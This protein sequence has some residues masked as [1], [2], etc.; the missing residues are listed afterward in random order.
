MSLFCALFVL[1]CSGSKKA[2][3]PVE[4]WKAEV[5]G[6]PGSAK[7][8]LDAGITSVPLEPDGLP[9]SSCLVYADGIVDGSPEEKIK[10]LMISL[11]PEIQFNGMGWDLTRAQNYSQRLDYRTSTITTSWVDPMLG[12]FKIVAHPDA[13]NVLARFEI[14]FKSSSNGEL[15]ISKQTAKPLPP[16]FIPRGRLID[17]RAD[18]T[19]N[20]Q[21]DQYSAA[22]L[23][24]ETKTF[25]ITFRTHKLAPIV[26]RETP[27]IE[28]DGPEEDQQIIASLEHQLEFV[29]SGPGGLGPF[30]TTSDR[31]FGHVFWDAD[32]WVF[33]ALALT[34]PDQAA[35]ISRYRLGTQAGMKDNFQEWVR[36]NLTI[37]GLLKARPKV[38]WESSKSGRETAVGDSRHQ[39]HISATVALSL[40]QSAALNLANSKQVNEFG[41]GV[42]EY[43]ELRATQTSRGWELKDVM[44][45]DEY[46]I[47]DNDLYTNLAVQSLFDCHGINRKLVLPKDAKGQFL[48]Y[49]NDPLKAYQQAA[50]VLAIYPLQ[51]PEAEK[52]A[53]QMLER[54]GPLVN[55]NGPAM[56][57]SLHALI[58]ARYGDSAEAH[59]EWKQSWKRYAKPPF[60]SISERPT[61]Q[62][63]IFVTGAAGYLNTVIYGFAGMRVDTKPWDK[64]DWKMPITDGYCLSAKSNLPPSWKSLRIRIQILGK[65]YLVTATQDGSRLE[66][67]A[68]APSSLD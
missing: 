64:A 23:P 24:G 2:D 18:E 53:I 59:R 50:A 31:Y 56:S 22:Y 33:P 54:F 21:E 49:D 43:Y 5:T 9:A 67:I 47:G 3:A 14:E 52:Q 13:G 38:A 45:P 17:V 39:E 20:D 15:V 37:T 4:L 60:Y 32:A 34:R 46:H 55:K 19:F 16:E 11:R 1:G 66:P 42:A 51:N 58:R 10:P 29:G 27:A 35:S 44:S 36:K 8:Y 25:S 30:A 62:Q 28:L 63:T 61:T 40:R 26:A 48:T 6:E 12:E 41:K 65:P 7:P 68:A 57:E